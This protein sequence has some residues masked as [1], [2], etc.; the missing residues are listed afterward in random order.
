MPS[1]ARVTVLVRVPLARIAFVSVFP[2]QPRFCVLRR[3]F[4]FTL[5][6]VIG[7]MDDVAWLALGDRHVQRVE[8]DVRLEARRHRPSDDAAA[9][10]IEDDGEVQETGPRGHIR[11][12]R[13]PELVGTARREVALDQVVGR[14]TGRITHGR[15]RRFARR[16]SD[17]PGVMHEPRDALLAD[18]LALRCE[19]GMEPRHAVGAA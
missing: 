14:T 11:D 8:D 6:A 1:D 10:C 16:D 12:V 5:T 3:P 15:E 7:M 4:E 9:P 13:D 18:V 17:E 2:S 19:L